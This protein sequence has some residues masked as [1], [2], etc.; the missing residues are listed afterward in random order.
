M[1]SSS[2]TPQLLT[3]NK[4]SFC[5]SP[6]SIRF[7]NKT[8]QQQHQRRRPISAATATTTERPPPRSSSPYLRFS[9]S[10]SSSSSSLYELLGIEMGA[11]CQEIKTAYRKLAR[12]LHPDVA[13]I[14]LKDSSADNFMKIHAAYSTLSDPQ[15]RA[16]YDRNLFVGRRR[17]SSSSSYYA[18]ATTSSSA[19]SGYSRRGNWETDQCW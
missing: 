18:T 2:F 15:K 11:S 14:D 13:A 19:S 4:T 8:Q 10:F 7:N 17:T 9:T 12:V 3:C 16:D 1:I 5:N 6:D